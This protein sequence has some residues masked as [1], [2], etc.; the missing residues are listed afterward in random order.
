MR[1]GIELRFGIALHCPLE[2]R[3]EVGVLALVVA[4]DA[5]VLAQAFAGVGAGIDEH[6]FED[7]PAW[8]VDPMHYI[9]DQKI[10]AH[11]FHAPR[12]FSLLRISVACSR[13]RH[14]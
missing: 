6:V 12:S 1:V 9:R 13:V 10:T 4:A 2:P 3:F 7:A 5:A 11:A 14:T 8:P